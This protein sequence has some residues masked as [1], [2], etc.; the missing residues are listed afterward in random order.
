MIISLTQLEFRER[1][2]RLFGSRISVVDGDKRFTYAGFMNG[3][4][5]AGWATHAI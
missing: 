1:A 3:G 2:V 4:S 5:Y